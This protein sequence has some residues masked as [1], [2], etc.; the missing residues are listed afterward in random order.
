MPDICTEQIPYGT[1]FTKAG[2]YYLQDQPMVETRGSNNRAY[3]V[4]RGRVCV[5]MMDTACGLRPAT[6]EF[7]ISKPLNYTITYE[8]DGGSS[9][10]ATTY[11]IESEYKGKIS[12]DSTSMYNIVFDEISRT[13]RRIIR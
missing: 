12:P 10:N 7:T 1:A 5:S 11:T 6:M 3:R 8:L 9:K 4:R 13:S 2:Q